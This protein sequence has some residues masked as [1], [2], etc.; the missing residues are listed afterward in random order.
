MRLKRP[1]FILLVLKL[2]LFCEVFLVQ[3]VFADFNVCS[4]FVHTNKQMYR[5]IDFLQSMEGVYQLGDCSVE[6]HTCH[7]FAT[8]NAPGDIV[9]DLLIRNSAGDERYIQ[10]E[11]PEADSPGLQVQILN[12]RI[13]FHYEFDDRNGSKEEGG[14]E[15]V[16]LEFLKSAD[17]KNLLSVEEGWYSTKDW[18]SRHAGSVYRWILCHG[19][20]PT[21][22]ELKAQ[23]NIEP[24]AQAKAQLIAPV[25]SVH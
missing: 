1:G 17:Q 10:L 7:T 16:R 5:A 20:V 15:S 9:G 12:G 8:D 3:P 25:I 13:M 24:S 11:F 18:K 2:T 14:L 6:I 19:S 21:N 23:E 4:N 22:L